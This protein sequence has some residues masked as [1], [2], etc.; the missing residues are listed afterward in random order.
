[1]FYSPRTEGIHRLKG[2]STMRTAQSVAVL[3]MA[4]LSAC[5]A[6]SGFFGS[7]NSL[8]IGSR[9]SSESANGLP[10]AVPASVVADLETA[11]AIDVKVVRALTDWESGA[12]RLLIWDETLTMAAGDLASDLD[13]ITLT[14]NGET[15]AFVA[16]VAPASNGQ[17]DWQSYVNSVGAVSGSG[18]I[19]SY[20]YGP[21]ALLSGEFG[22]EAFFVFGHETDPDEIAALVGNILDYDGIFEGFGQ[23]VDPANGNVLSSEE[24]FSGTLALTAD[25]TG[26]TVTGDLNGS[27]DYD[28]TAFTTSF[29]APIEGNGY[30]GDLDT[31]NCTNAVCLSNSQVGG[32][33][34]GTDALETSGVLGMD[35]RVD[36]NAGSEYQFIS[37][38]SYTAEQ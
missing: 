19:Y 1:M 15:L 13:N 24:Y 23:V 10:F 3:A 18:T 37:G 31:M 21:S 6:G 36:P 33:F 9:S 5:T 30:L 35:V 12:T 25:F 4:T 20:N 28:G 17:N 27:F 11:G 14:L 26:G 22:T 2:A 16:G 38:G 34:F 7:N 32:A 8:F 29:S